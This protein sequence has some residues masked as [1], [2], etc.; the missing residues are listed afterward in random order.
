MEPSMSEYRRALPRREEVGGGGAKDVEG[1]R[2]ENEQRE[3]EK[4][5]GKGKQEG[6]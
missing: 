3:G 6:Q 4:S 1:R 5:R 2:K